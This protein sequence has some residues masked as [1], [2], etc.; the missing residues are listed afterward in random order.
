MALMSRDQTLIE[1]FRKGDDIHAQ[2]ASL[3]FDTPPNLVTKAQRRKAKTINFGILYGMG[4]YSLSTDLNI[5]LKEAK[6]FI[7]N[8]F[9]HFPNVKK[10]QDETKKFAHKKEYVKTLFQRKR[11]LKYINSRN[12]NL[13]KFAER[14]A[15]N[16]PI[17]GTSADII[18]IAMYKIHEKIKGNKNEI[19]MIIQ[20]HDELVFEI[21]KDV[22]AKYEEIIRQ[23][24]ENVLP[25]EYNGIVPLVVD[26][27]HGNNWLQAH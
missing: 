27:D 24:M 23:E 17:Q 19:M 22:L 7:E 18:K 6:L 2:T 8:Y 11:F 15:I 14:T 9:N 21:K 3:I 10:Y 5:T 12:G 16:M 25:D 1:T 4:P 26:L 13:R 20:I